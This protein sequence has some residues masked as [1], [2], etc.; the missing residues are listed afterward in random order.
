MPRK[1][2]ATSLVVLV[3][4]LSSAGFAGAASPERSPLPESLEGS[5]VYWSQFVDVHFSGSRIVAADPH[6]RH[7]RALTHPGPGVQDIDP[8][9]SS[10]GTRILFERDLP[11]TSVIGIVRADGRG[12]R[13]L[14]L[15][16]TDPCVGVGTPSWTP[17]GRHII[18]TRGIGPFDQVN[19]SLRSGV[20]WRSNLDGSHQVRLSERGI[21]GAYEDYNATFAPD[22]Y[23]VFMRIRNAD[24]KSAAFRMDADGSDV[25]RLTPWA[26]DADE[27]SVSPA[28][29][30]P[31]EDLVVFETYGHGPPDGVAQAIATVSAKS[32]CG[33][34]CLSHVRYLTSP[35]SLPVQN[36]NPSW[37]PDGQE[38]AYVKFS[39]IQTDIP[40]VR[41]DI[42]RMRWDG[43]G[44]APV[45]R[46]P[47]LF[48]FRPT[49]GW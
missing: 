24:I 31:T 4:V 39:Y 30:G 19:G 41:G 48:D 22:G 34:H 8:K 29:S 10:Q 16:C 17:D 45:S 40:P 14:D 9:V 3:W 38:I 5:T 46:S 47:I 28:P 6:G 12:E 23:I 20:L 33:D 42:W 1:S 18:Y 15:R 44:K 49:W 11:D 7:F 21:D 43:E 37:S 25:R 26:L 27:L 35:N 13:V 32:Q 36:F 2:F